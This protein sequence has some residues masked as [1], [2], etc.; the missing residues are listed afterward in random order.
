MLLAK[1]AEARSS[2][3]TFLPAFFVEPL[4]RGE[5]IEK[6]NEPAHIALYPPIAMSYRPKVDELVRFAVKDVTASEVELGKREYTH[7][8]E[9]A[10]RVMGNVSLSMAYRAIFTMFHSFSRETISPFRPTVAV[11]YG[12][13]LLREGQKFA[14]DSISIIETHDQTDRWEVVDIIA[15]REAQS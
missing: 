14:F 2:S 8:S 7:N 4:E 10:F 13:S 11:P 3:A 9:S 6:G 15:L 5:M 1:E 12:P